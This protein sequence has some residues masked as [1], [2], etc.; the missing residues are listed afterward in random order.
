MSKR[1]PSII[2]DVNHHLYYRK[3]QTVR[4]SS[5]SETHLS[6]T[7]GI[8]FQA[9]NFIGL[10]QSPVVIKTCLELFFVNML[11]FTE[12]KNFSNLLF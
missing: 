8:V 10:F 1:A 2:S 3:P 4:T 9:V 7:N 11:N 5:V 6:S 12:K